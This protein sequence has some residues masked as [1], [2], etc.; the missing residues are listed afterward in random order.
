MDVRA[1]IGANVKRLRLA[2][3]LTQEQLA[4]R[5]DFD[6]RYISQLERGQ[7]N[8]TVLSCTRSLKR[9]GPPPLSF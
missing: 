6:Q 1:V 2:L 8:P 7:R 5:C 9:S 4:D 3:G